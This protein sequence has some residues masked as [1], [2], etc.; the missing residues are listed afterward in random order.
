M[1]SETDEGDCPVAESVGEFVNMTL[2]S[3]EQIGLRI[4]PVWLP[5][6]DPC[7]GWSAPYPQYLYDLVSFRNG[8]NGIFSKE[9]GDIHHVRP[10]L[11][12]NGGDEIS[13]RSPVNVPATE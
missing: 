11:I 3:N 5:V 10:A 7:N 1:E 12:E 2:H 8:G 4:Y 13:G 9:H 6:T